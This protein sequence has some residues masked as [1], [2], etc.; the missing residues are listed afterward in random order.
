MSINKFKMSRLVDQKNVVHIHNGILFICEKSE[1]DVYKKIDEAKDYKSS[2]KSQT[3]KDRGLI[4]YLTGLFNAESSFTYKHT[5]THTHTHTREGGGKEGRNV[6]P[7]KNYNRD[8]TGL[9]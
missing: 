4:E 9:M 6:F 5:H 7:Q 2:K 1:F 3:Q 8:I